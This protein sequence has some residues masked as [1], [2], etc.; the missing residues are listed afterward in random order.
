MNVL[1]TPVEVLVVTFQRVNVWIPIAQP[2]WPEERTV[3]RSVPVERVREYGEERSAVPV[4]PLAAEMMSRK[5]RLVLKETW[6]V[7]ARHRTPGR[8]T[9]HASSSPGGTL[10]ARAS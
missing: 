9:H 1:T 5:C 7:G 4:G 8:S 2:F 10:S 3:A 6:V